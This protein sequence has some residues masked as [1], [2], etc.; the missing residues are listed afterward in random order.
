MGHKAC[1]FMVTV[2]KRR[3]LNHHWS[4]RRGE[5]T[6][7]VVV[8][9]VFEVVLRNGIFPVDNLQ[10]G[11]VLERVLLK[12]Q[13]VEDASE[14]LRRREVAKKVLRKTTGIRQTLKGWKR[15]DPDVLFLIDGEVGVEVDHLWGPVRRSGVSCDL[16]RTQDMR[17]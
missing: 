9:Y 14:C 15:S 16:H 6:Y 2:E 10:F 4:L 8:D 5:H 13:E 17:R 11:S 12:T 1:L 3:V 7:E